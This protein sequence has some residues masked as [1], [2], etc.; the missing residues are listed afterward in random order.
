MKIRYRKKS[1]KTKKRIDEVKANLNSYR[2]SI[3]LLNGYA[4]GRL[5]LKGGDYC[6]RAACVKRTPEDDERYHWTLKNIK[7]QMILLERELET[8]LR[9]GS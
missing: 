6:D 1:E 9:Y 4:E 7:T 5:T 2:E 8:L 3:E